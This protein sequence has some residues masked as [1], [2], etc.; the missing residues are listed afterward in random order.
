[1]NEH[2]SQEDRDKI[3]PPKDA[4]LSGIKNKILDIP[5]G[6]H[7]KQK[8]DILYPNKEQDLYPAILFIHGGAFVGGHKQ[9][10]QLTPYLPF[11]D[12]GYAIVG[13]DYRL[14]G[15]AVFPQGIQDCNAALR[16]VKAHAE[17]YKLDVNRIGAVGDS[18]GANFVLMM[19]TTA[20]DTY[21]ED[22]S[23]NDCQADTKLQAVC[24]WFTPTDM[25][26]MDQQLRESGLDDFAN[27]SEA[28]SPESVYL[29][30]ALPELDPDLVAKAS[31]ITH[32][33]EAM[34]PIFMQHGRID[35]IVPY[36]QSVTF[37][38]KAHKIVGDRIQ[39]EIIEGANHAD[40]KIEDPNNVAKVIG[41]FDEY[42]K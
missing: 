2:L 22:Y 21:F 40:P 23:I 25:S 24:V 19:V 12:A 37:Y 38:E 7:E 5:Y 8:L 16:F 10:A 35:F 33:H 17:E 13:I 26:N 20:G 29:G 31:P 9:D 4:D 3:A 1:M 42:L 11:L 30:G 6:S 28:D 39:L 32:I 34:P 15:E 27:H 36:Q 18:S 41:F 14:A